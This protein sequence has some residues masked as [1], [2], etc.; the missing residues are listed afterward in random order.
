MPITQVDSKNDLIPSVRTSSGKN[1]SKASGDFASKMQDAVSAEKNAAS[2]SSLG[3]TKVQKTNTGQLSDSDGR[4]LT[5]KLETLVE[6]LLEL[7]KKSDGNS[8]AKTAEIN[9]EI[10]ALLQQIYQLLGGETNNSLNIIESKEIVQNPVSISGPLIYMK[11]GGPGRQEVAD[12]LQKVTDFLASL[13]KTGQVLLPEEFMNKLNQS[14]V[15]LNKNLAGSTTGTDSPKPADVSLQS[16][17]LNQPDKVF[18]SLSREEQL[19][20]VRQNDTNG[21]ND[22]AGR[23]ATAGQNEP[24]KQPGQS[25]ALF[26]GDSTQAENE[27]TGS[28]ALPKKNEPTKVG[29]LQIQDPMPMMASSTQNSTGTR[30]DTLHTPLIPARFFAREM[31]AV[32]VKQAMQNKGTGAYEM[33]VRLF[34]EN[35]GQ[36][37][38]KITALNGQITAQFIATSTAGKEAIE[39]QMDQL[40]QALLQHGLHPEKLEVTQAAS[41]PAS[42]GDN[43]MFNQREGSEQH[44]QENNREQEKEQAEFSLDLASLGNGEAVNKELGDMTTKEVNVAI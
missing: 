34:P 3:N 2:N 31:E 15:L 14:I 39:R 12:L 42:Q 9:P 11:Q 5:K 26:N 19:S 23:N 20:A 36:V 10:Y 27:Q 7:S 41:S 43:Q 28:D 38:V 4:A 25:T 35:L 16:S 6:A 44:Q 21:Q 13:E 17:K 29:H 30:S 8:G 32:M 1:N 22:T 33:T 40:H 18:S 24:V 37:D